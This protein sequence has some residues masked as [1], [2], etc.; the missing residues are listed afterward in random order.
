MQET[1]QNILVSAVAGGVCSGA[2]V[3]LFKSWISERLKNA[4]AFEY[5]EKLKAVEHGYDQQL[6]KLRAQ[7]QSDSLKAKEE[8]EHD[9]K[10]FEKLM[11]YCDETTLRDFCE[12]TAAYQYYDWPNCRKV[13][14]LE[15]Y[16][17]QDENQFVN[18]NLREAFLAFHKTLGE[19][20]TVIARDFFG[21]SEDRYMLY[22]E[23]RHSGDA[24]ERERFEA[25]R[26]ET[27]NAGYKTLE[28]FSTFRQVVKQTLFI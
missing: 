19:F 11:S 24:E 10:I 14:D 5:A 4:I 13:N 1:L 20:S 12:T 22:P 25:A 8:L 17:I 27:K 3:W 9:R 23:L 2:I 18:V 16:G 21:V 26:I 15:H 6:E 7:L 28:A